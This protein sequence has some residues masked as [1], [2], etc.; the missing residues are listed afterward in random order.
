[1]KLAQ[2][3]VE[4]GK[5][6]A[7]RYKI[8]WANLLATGAR[9]ATPLMRAAAPVVAKAAPV[10]KSIAAN[11]TARSMA[12]DM[13]AQMVMNKMTQPSLPPQPT[14]PRQRPGTW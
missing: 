9:L 6:A 11:P 10:I 8:A 4:G 1:M 5:A 12:A 2:A 14:Q 13:G 3:Y 7:D